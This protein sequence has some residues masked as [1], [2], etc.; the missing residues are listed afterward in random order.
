M[1]GLEPTLPQPSVP[2]LSYSR[3][4]KCSLMPAQDKVLSRVPDKGFGTLQP[5][6]ALLPTQISQSGSN[7]F[8]A[9]Y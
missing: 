1:L 3:S 8:L 7:A 2:T 5:P 4:I 9:H 6:G